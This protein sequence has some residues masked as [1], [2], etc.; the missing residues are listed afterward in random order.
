[1]KPGDKVAVREKSK[2]LEAIASSVSGASN[3]YSWMDFN[4][5]NMEGTF[6]TMPDRTQIPENIKEQLIVELYS[7]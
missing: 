1:L 2:S 5:S 3:A 6:L 7:K 4:K